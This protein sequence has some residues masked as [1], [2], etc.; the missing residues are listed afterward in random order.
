MLKNKIFILSVFFNLGFITTLSSQLWQKVGNGLSSNIRGLYADQ[1]SNKLYIA[2]HFKYADTLTC[3]GIAYWDGNK[4]GS[5]NSPTGLNCWSG[6]CDPVFSIAKFNNSFFIS[7]IFNYNNKVEY[8]LENIN[9]QWTPSCNLHAG[10]NNLAL[11]NGKL[12]SLGWFDSVCSKP[13]QRIAVYENNSWNEFAPSNGVFGSYG[14]EMIWCAEYYNGDYYFAGNT[15]S[16]S[17]FKEIIRYRGS[18]WQSLQNGILGDAWVN[19]LKVYKDVLYVGGLFYKSEGN[20]AD[21]LMAWDG[22][23]WYDPFPKIQYLEQIKDL[24]VINDQLYIA[25][26]FVIPADNDSLMYS[27]ARFNGC[28]YGSFGLKT[29]FPDYTNPPMAIESLSGKIYAAVSDSIE[30]KST[31]YL[32]SFDG[33]LDNFR[34]IEITSCEKTEADVSFNLYPN[35]FE[36]TLYLSSGEKIADLEVCIFNMLGQLVYKTTFDLNFQGNLYLENLDLGVYYITLKKD[37]NTILSKKIVKSGNI[38]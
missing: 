21:F 19:C 15:G 2:G 35:P 14:A 34:N 26:N 12:F 10:G 28:N 38:K 25:G 29:K 1:T 6:N 22:Q 8:L 17:G 23:K 16:Q 5:F 18:Q 30:H 4:Y 37:S 20:A 13:S 32:I 11:A 36:N 3:K 31:G 33:N 7:G 27:I 9:N 24:K